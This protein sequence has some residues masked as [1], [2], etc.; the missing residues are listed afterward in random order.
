MKKKVSLCLMCILICLPTVSAQIAN[1]GF[2]Q[3]DGNG[4][5]VSWKATNVPPAY[6]TIIKTSDAHSG[7]WAAKG[8]VVPF[9]IFTVGPSLISGEEAQGIPVNFRPAAIEGYYKFISVQDDYLQIQAN[10]KK[11]G[12]YIGGGA[13]NLT[14]ANSYTK[15]SIANSFITADVPDSV[16]IAIFIASTTGLGHIGSTM[17][18]DDLAWGSATDINDNL[19]QTPSQ[20]VLNQNFPNPFNPSTTINFSIPTSEFVTLKVYDVLGKEVGTLVNEENPAGS[21]EVEFNAADLS[22]GIYFYKLHAGSF[23]ETKKMVL[24]Q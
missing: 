13:N 11:D 23:I 14:P 3:W 2:E 1:S 21:Y 16:V 9:S 12:F 20:F 19:S 15:F 6:T 4:N 10:F 24:I 22:T 7:S 8:D 18:I 17:Y 5:P